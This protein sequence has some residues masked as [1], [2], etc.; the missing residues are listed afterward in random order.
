MKLYVHRGYRIQTQVTSQW[1]AIVWAPG[2]SRASTQLSKATI[3][4]GELVSLQRAKALI[5]HWESQAD[6]LRRGVATT[7][8]ALSA[9]R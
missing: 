8:T 5:D 1:Q 7:Q 6:L 9:T 2:S 3:A 4:E